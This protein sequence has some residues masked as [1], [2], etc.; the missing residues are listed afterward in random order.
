MEKIG[1]TVDAQTFNTIIAGLDELPHRISRPV[2]DELVKQ[3]QPQINKQSEHPNG[4]LSDKVI[5]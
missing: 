4:P 1:L 5:Q 3:A 2:I